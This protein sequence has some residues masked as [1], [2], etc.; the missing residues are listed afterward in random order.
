[1]RRAQQINWLAWQWYCAWL[2][3]TGDTVRG[4]VMSLRDVR[5]GGKNSQHTWCQRIWLVPSFPL[6]KSGR[7]SVGDQKQ[8][9]S[10]KFQIT[11]YLVLVLISFK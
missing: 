4:M 9:W 8:R 11:F 2:H 1:M 5:E 10:G 6:K 7:V 3:I